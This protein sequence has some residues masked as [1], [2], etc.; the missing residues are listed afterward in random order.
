MTND[1]ERT[2]IS[3]LPSSSSSPIRRSLLVRVACF[4]SWA[5]DEVVSFKSER[6]VKG[7]PWEVRGGEEAKDGD[8]TGGEDEVIDGEW[9]GR[10]GMAGRE[11]RGEGAAVGV[12]LGDTVIGW[13]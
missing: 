4:S 8:V 3:L 6:E 9:V 2:L 5:K 11:V 7:E 1:G 10:E 12:E 13:S